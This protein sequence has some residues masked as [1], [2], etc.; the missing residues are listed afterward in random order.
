MENWL[1]INLESLR[2]N[3]DYIKSKTDTNIISVIKADGYGMGS[4]EIAKEL[5]RLGTHMFAVAFF[6]EA[7]ELRREGIKKEILIFNYISPENLTKCFGKDYILTIYSVDQLKI[8]ISQLGEDLKKLKFH[9]KVNTGMNRL[10]ID[11]CEI[12]ELSNLIREKQYR[13][14]GYILTFFGC[15]GRL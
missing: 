8:Y 15:R 12:E 14:R 3:Y 7:E 6:K 2:N 11:F 13:S 9:L 5:E 1:E 4:F 10:G